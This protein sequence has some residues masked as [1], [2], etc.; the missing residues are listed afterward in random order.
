MSRTYEGFV[1]MKYNESDFHAFK[2]K[3]PEFE[4]FKLFDK[5]LI[6]SGNESNPVF[7]LEC[8]KPQCIYDLNQ[9]IKAYRK[10]NDGRDNFDPDQNDK[11]TCRSCNQQVLYKNFQISYELKNYLIQKSLDPYDVEIEIISNQDNLNKAKKIPDMNDYNSK[12]LNDKEEKFMGNIEECFKLDTNDHLLKFNNYFGM[13]E[14]SLKQFLKDDM[15]NT[16]IFI[17]ALNYLQIS[18]S[19]TRNSRPVP[20]F[21]YTQDEYNGFERASNF[22]RDFNH[23]RLPSFLEEFKEIVII[24]E[25]INE[26]YC[27][28]VQYNNAEFNFL[29]NYVRFFRKKVDL[30]EDYFNY[31]GELKIGEIKTPFDI[32]THIIKNHF[33]VLSDVGF[34][35]KQLEQ[36]KVSIDNLK[37]EFDKDQIEKL[38]THKDYF[39]KGVSLIPEEDPWLLEELQYRKSSQIFEALTYFV[40]AVIQSPEDENSWFYIGVCIKLLGGVNLCAF[41]VFEQALI[42]DENN[43]EFF[44]FLADSIEESTPD[45]LEF[46]DKAIELDENFPYPYLV[47]AKYYMNK[48]KKQTKEAIECL[49]KAT[50]LDPDYGIAWNMLG[51][52]QSGLNKTTE[53]LK[54]Y[55]KAIEVYPTYNAPIL[56]ICKEELKKNKFDSIIYKC[57]NAI[58]SGFATWEIYTIYSEVFD[59]K[60]KSAKQKETFEILDKGIEKFPSIGHFNKQKGLLY[61]RYKNKKDAILSY[62]A[63]GNEFS[64]NTFEYNEAI[65]C[66][67][68]SLKIDA[69]NIEA[70]NGCAYANTYLNRITDAMNDINKSLQ[71]DPNNGPAYTMKGFIL[72]RNDEHQMAIE[73]FDK[74]ISLGHIVSTNY[75][76]KAF[77]LYKINKI[78]DALN[79]IDT[80]MSNNVSTYYSYLVKARCLFKKKDVDMALE[81]LDICLKLKPDF[82]EGTQALA[83]IHKFLYKNKKNMSGAVTNYVKAYSYYSANFDHLDEFKNDKVPN[84]KSI[85]DKDVDAEIWQSELNESYRKFECFLGG[86]GNFEAKDGSEILK[87]VFDRYLNDNIADLKRKK[88]EDFVNY[89]L[90]IS[91][92]DLNEFKEMVK[93]VLLSSFYLDQEKEDEAEKITQT[94]NKDFETTKKILQIVDSNPRYKKFSKREADGKSLKPRKKLRKEI[95]EK[96][97]MTSDH[98]E[99]LKAVPEPFKKTSKYDE[100]NTLGNKEFEKNKKNKNA[101]NQ[102]SKIDEVTESNFTSASNLSRIKSNRDSDMISIDKDELQKMMDK[103]KEDVVGKYGNKYDAN[104][105][106][107]FNTTEMSSGEHENNIFEHKVKL[108]KEEQQDFMNFYALLWYYYYYDI[109]KYKVLW[110]EYENKMS[111]I[112]QGSIGMD[113]NLLTENYNNQQNLLGTPAPNIENNMIGQ[114]MP[115]SINQTGSSAPVINAKLVGKNEDVKFDDCVSRVSVYSSNGNS[116]ISKISGWNRN[117]NTTIQVM[118]PKP[119][120]TK[121]TL[122]RS[123]TIQA[124]LKSPSPK[125]LQRIGCTETLIKGSFNFADNEDT[126]NNEL[127][128]QRFKRN[129]NA[130]GAYSRKSTLIQIPKN[131]LKLKKRDYGSNNQIIKVKSPESSKLNTGRKTANNDENSRS[132]GNLASKQIYSQMSPNSENISSFNKETNRTGKKATIPISLNINRRRSSIDAREISAQRYDYTN[133]HKHSPKKHHHNHNNSGNV[134]FIEPQGNIFNFSSVE[135]KISRTQLQPSISEQKLG[136]ANIASHDLHKQ[137]MQK[138]PALYKQQSIS[139]KELPEMR[140]SGTEALMKRN[141]TGGAVKPQMI[142]YTEK[143]YYNDSQND[144]DLEKFKN[145]HAV[146]DNNAVNHKDLI[147]L[148]DKNKMSENVLNYFFSYY[149]NKQLQMPLDTLQKY[150]SRGFFFSTEFHRLYVTDLAK[151]MPGF[152]YDRV[153]YMTKDYNGKGYT[154]LHHFDKIFFPLIDEVTNTFKLMTAIPHTKQLVL[155]DPLL[156]PSESKRK[157]P[158]LQTNKHFSIIANY[159]KEEFYEKGGIHI[160]IANEWNFSLADCSPTQEKDFTGLYVCKYIHMILK[161]ITNPFFNNNDQNKFKKMLVENQKKRFI[162]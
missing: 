15:F 40:K 153:K 90:K 146:L 84:L 139:E 47:K 109:E 117:I 131:N 93:W 21:L 4:Y 34:Q 140:R 99:F 160:D 133:M 87:Q 72:L 94:L 103:V 111:G 46:I 66:Y 45:K 113:P 114:M 151:E 20:I 122:L 125:D 152:R 11:F 124:D 23:K 32:L 7:N 27:F 22:T 143:K 61:E 107:T 41:Q 144:S 6:A 132:S 81:C 17:A 3:Y 44:T 134:D 28:F 65:E 24:V 73:M 162:T 104:E 159:L 85:I 79:V 51:E 70:L 26:Y 54:C 59:R 43:S 116:C 31:K 8:N 83:N 126:G 49:E 82:I 154:I 112:V 108:T 86:D 13:S 148:Q 67:K 77:I 2:R 55:N 18:Y 48:K 137:N 76:E 9:I 10:L 16:D 102:H 158:K 75:D 115:N 155:F 142:Q 141:L 97:K 58:D 101:S 89:Y 38:L 98:S 39:D 5:E 147:D 60:T 136:T 100:E 53:A 130:D 71:I 80:C 62:N 37:E 121:L 145:R 25:Y 96:V 69:K 64:I 36:P 110:K 33:P 95:Y 129:S 92:K 118:K 106:G 52:I 74:S 119:K 50:L 19:Q 138:Y 123:S 29:Y 68:Y 156:L 78:D 91:E 150:R 88:L 56:N 135:P 128:P 35:L 157:Y 57:N 149:K 42:I 161:G 105:V 120:P 1:R 30:R 14:E 12:D 127:S 63:A